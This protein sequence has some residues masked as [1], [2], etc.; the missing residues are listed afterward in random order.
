[1]ITS[2]GAETLLRLD[3]PSSSSSSSGDGGAG[4]VIDRILSLSRGAWTT[5]LAELALCGD[6]PLAYSKV[7]SVDV[8]SGLTLVF[9]TC[10]GLVGPDAYGERLVVLAAGRRCARSLLKQG[11]ASLAKECAVALPFLDVETMDRAVLARRVLEGRYVQAQKKGSQVADGQWLPLRFGAAVRGDRKYSAYHESEGEIAANAHILNQFTV[12][13]SQV[14]SILEGAE[15]AFKMSSQETAIVSTRD[16]VL[17]IGRS[18]TGK[19]TCAVLK[20]FASHAAFS[21]NAGRILLDPR[22]LALRR[23]AA[24]RSRQ[25]ALTSRAGPDA[26]PPEVP[27]EIKDEDT[28]H[29]GVHILFITVAPIL[30]GEIRNY[31]RKMA[32]L[33]VDEMSKAGVRSK[34]NPHDVGGDDND[35]DDTVVLSAPTTTNNNNTTST[36]SKPR[37]NVLDEVDEEEEQLFVDLPPSLLN[38]CDADFPLFLT[39]RRFLLMLDGTLHEPFFA[40]TDASGQLVSMDSNST[41]NPSGRVQVKINK[42]SVLVGVA[43]DEAEAGGASGN[44]SGDGDNDGDGDWEDVADEVLPPVTAEDAETL[45]R[46]N[47][48]R[49]NNKKRAVNTVVVGTEVDYEIFAHVIYPQIYPQVRSSSYYQQQTNSSSFSSS[50]SSSSHEV[51]H[52]SVIYT[53]IMSVIKG[54]PRSIRGPLTADEY[55]VS[56]HTHFKGNRYFV[57]SFFTLYQQF[58]KSRSMYDIE[59]VIHY[60]FA[61]LEFEGYRGVPIHNVFV[62][63]VQDMT[64][65]TLKLLFEICR[66]PKG[67]FFAGD[68]CQTIARG[69]GFRFCD[70]YWTFGSAGTPLSRIVPPAIRQLTV[71]FRSHRNILNLGHSVVALLERFFPQSIDRLAKDR[72]RGIGPKPAILHLTPDDLF[73]VLMGGKVGKEPGT[74][75]YIEFG[76]RQV[77]LV[78][79]EE[80]KKRLPAVFSH[81]LCM[82][83]LEAKGLEF[84][85][86]VL[87]NFFTDS[88]VRETWTVVPPAKMDLGIPSK[89]D[90]EEKDR[91]RD[92]SKDDVARRYEDEDSV[93]F[94]SFE[95][96]NMVDPTTGSAS[97]EAV[98]IAMLN[99]KL[100]VADAARLKA[101]HNAKVGVSRRSAALS[102]DGTDAAAAATAATAATA[103]VATDAATAAAASAAASNE[104]VPVPKELLFKPGLYNPLNEWL[105]ARYTNPEITA[106]DVA[107]YGPA[108]QDVTKKVQD[109]RFLKWQ[110]FFS[111]RE[112]GP[113]LCSELKHL[114]TAVTRPKRRLYI[115]DSDPD[116]SAPVYRFW[117]AN[118]LVDV[119]DKDDERVAAIA[120][121]ASPAEWRKQGVAMYRRK[122]YAAAMR[123]FENSGDEEYRSRAECFFIAEQAGRCASHLEEAVASL[124]NRLALSALGGRFNYSATSTSA[125]AATAA[126]TSSAEAFERDHWTQ[127][128][129]DL[130][131]KSLGLYLE[132]AQRF[133]AAGLTRQAAAFFSLAGEPSRAA[134][135]F[136]VMGAHLDAARNYSMAGC[137]REAGKYALLGGDPELAFL[138]FDRCGAH[139]EF[140][141]VLVTGGAGGHVGPREWMDLVR[142]Y[143]ARA[144]AASPVAASATFEL[145]GGLAA[146]VSEEARRAAAYDSEEVWVH[147]RHLLAK[148]LPAMIREDS[149]LE[150]V[151][152]LLLELGLHHLHLRF[153]RTHEHRMDPAER[154]TLVR[155]AISKLAHVLYHRRRGMDG[156]ARVVTGWRSAATFATEASMMYGDWRC[157]AKILTSV[158]LADQARE[159]EADLETP[160]EQRA[161]AD[162]E[163]GGG[164]GALS[165]SSVEVN[166]RINLNVVVSLALQALRSNGPLPEEEATELWSR[167]ATLSGQ[168]LV[169]LARPLAVRC[170][171]DSP[172][173]TLMLDYV[174]AQVSGK[175]R[176]VEAARSLLRGALS[177]ESLARTSLSICFDAVKILCSSEAATNDDI[178]VASRTT[179]EALALAFG[180]LLPKSRGERLSP[181]EE[182]LRVELR[183]QRGGGM[184]YTERY[185]GMKGYLIV[186]RSAKATLSTA[187]KIFGH[188]AVHALGPGDD[189]LAVDGDA[190]DLACLSDIL[191][192]ALGAVSASSNASLRLVKLPPDVLPGILDFDL[193]GSCPFATRALALL[194]DLF[195]DVDRVASMATSFRAA[196]APSALTRFFET[197]EKARISRI[198][199]VASRLASPILWLMPPGAA[200]LTGYLAE[201]ASSFGYQH[202]AAAKNHFAEAVVGPGEEFAGHGEVAL[203]LR[204]HALAGRTVVV[205]EFLRRVE[206]SDIA[207]LS[208]PLLD[209]AV[210][211]RQGPDV[212]SMADCLDRLVCGCTPESYPPSLIA[213][214]AREVATGIVARLAHL[215]HPSFKGARSVPLP[216]SLSWAVPSPSRLHALS[217]SFSASAADLG[218]ALACALKTLCAAY[219]LAQRGSWARHACAE[220]LVFALVAGPARDERLV[221]GVASAVASLPEDKD[222][223]ATSKTLKEWGDV[224]VGDLLLGPGLLGR[225]STLMALLSPVAS[226]PVNEPAKDR[227]VPGGRKS[228]LELSS[229]NDDDDDNDGNDNDDDDDDEYESSDDGKDGAASSVSASSTTSWDRVSSSAASSTS[230]SDLGRSDAS[231]IHVKTSKSNKNKDKVKDRSKAGSSK[232]QPKSDVGDLRAAQEALEAGAASTIQAWWRDTVRRRWM[233]EAYRA[234]VLER[235]RRVAAAVLISNSCWHFAFSGSADDEDAAGSSQ[236]NFRAPVAGL[237]PAA[238]TSAAAGSEALARAAQGPFSRALARLRLD[239]SRYTRTFNLLSLDR[240]GACA[241]LFSENA[242]LAHRCSSASSAAPAQDLAALL[243][244]ARAHLDAGS[245]LLSSWYAGHVALEA[246]PAR[247]TSLTAV[248]DREKKRIALKKKLRQAALERKKEL[249]KRSRK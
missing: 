26:P 174:H 217:A 18:G 247:S 74:S 228:G 3:S 213:G 65:C 241:V 7:Y 23:L 10:V 229:G 95:T 184:G 50:S 45:L 189:L 182:R 19:T 20:L 140:E 248:S 6:G 48:E 90:E 46:R 148:A 232:K 128:M 219:K 200:E 239:I 100:A 59:D 71:N 197:A 79:D 110:R 231:Y 80:A 83:I 208:L 27:P 109:H 105:D 61:R 153:L 193:F 24:A 49:L 43:A 155:S 225:S 194:R 75:T 55:Y 133:S 34:I 22:P 215:G 181:A 137:H 169:S 224:L 44:G 68:T 236:R 66:N 93:A 63:E 52:P 42:R 154:D 130:K 170:G 188:I 152:D 167:Y 69:I 89:E 209:L 211:R 132:A 195:A 91:A 92:R 28:E 21:A 173:L 8:A 108:Y 237:P 223:P 179:V 131:V 122:F 96:M 171:V 123:C 57:Y 234:E 47:R 164:G 147:G 218:L 168:D 102:A 186:G 60:I 121:K 116:V 15:L 31:Y 73:T 203:A 88:P 220:A 210:Y 39:L 114:Y 143:F 82:T 135:M 25:L 160:L 156:L 176:G 118:G 77:I 142:K 103:A 37:R 177:V 86:V 165:S 235:A 222:V 35:D 64:Q 12:P 196:I 13:D 111:S 134:E 149:P 124:R 54:G 249:I 207:R 84:D 190:F 11:I 125:A 38:L 53:E 175:G 94:A 159:V 161:R 216:A 67:F 58:L 129:R 99:Q 204:F 221:P 104:P 14:L 242:Q 146:E 246:A 145:L 98:A 32:K 16:N 201:I 191:D 120:E 166:E 183:R 238:T 30:C 76:A 172:V 187:G 230:W 151:A 2:F 178:V 51:L 157:V 119:V 214:L 78:R 206:P 62:D 138:S 158:G 4:L 198:S 205:D 245:D 33:H 85:D 233:E 113:L 81:A 127:E 9:A 41:W 115:F 244:A 144:L 240:T 29:T 139:S 126:A 150:D 243:K 202:L 40:R 87:Y 199:S 17:L 106:E 5:R 185:T 162:R 56:P 141:S 226:L 97:K 227:P 163:G 180:A 70:L 1:M 212:M 107:S 112:S 192:E 36:A 72:G 117:I 136:A 101:E